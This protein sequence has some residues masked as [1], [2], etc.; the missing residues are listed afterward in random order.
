MQAGEGL[1]HRD[2]IG[3]SCSQYLQV[4]LRAHFPPQLLTYVLVREALRIS[5][6]ITSRCEF[7]AEELPGYVTFQTY[8]CAALDSSGGPQKEIRW[9]K[10]GKF[11]NVPKRVTKKSKTLNCK[12]I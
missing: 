6:R 7:M 3:C 9:I 11:F 12:E 2:D 4:L 8:K 10:D 5:P 1:C